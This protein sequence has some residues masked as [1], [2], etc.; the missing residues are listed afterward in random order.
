M[1][2]AWLFSCVLFPPARP[3]PDPTD[4]LNYFLLFPL[5]F[6]LFVSAFLVNRFEY[7]NS[8]FVTILCRENRQERSTELSHSYLSSVTLACFYLFFALNFGLSTG[9]FW[10]VSVS[11]FFCLSLEFVSAC[12]LGRLTVFLFTNSA[13]VFLLALLDYLFNKLL[14]RLYFCLRVMSLDPLSC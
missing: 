9:L 3:S 13:F 6:C 8:V 10:P 14:F 2:V 12:C 5:V 4:Y 11:D 1:S 7:F